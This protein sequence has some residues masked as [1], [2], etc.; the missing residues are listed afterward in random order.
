MY[1]VGNAFEMHS[2]I[3]SGLI[4]GGKSLR[5]DKQSV[6]FTA[7]NP[8]CAR[9]DLEVVE[10]DLGKLRIA[11]Y[12]HTWKAHHNSSNLDHDW[13]SNKS[14]YFWRTSSWTELKKKKNFLLSSRRSAVDRYTFRTPLHLCVLHKTLHP[15]RAMSHTLQHTCTGTPSPPCSVQRSEEHCHDPRLLQRGTSAELPPLTST[16]HFNG[17]SVN[18]KLLFPTVHSVNQISVY[19]AVTDWCYQFGLT[20][21]EKEVAISVDNG[22][23]TMVEPE[24]V[25]LLV[26]VPTQAPG[27]GMQ[28]SVLS[29]RTWE[30]RIHMTQ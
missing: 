1:H 29:F 24:E 12:K 18:T 11:P 28:G 7:V 4:P 10:C 14:W 9:Q 13:K 21:E 8:M 17:D 6:F 15:L 20:N 30:K 22:I 16:I 19:E 5:R 26:S 23:M 3:R 25:E 27:N 2:I